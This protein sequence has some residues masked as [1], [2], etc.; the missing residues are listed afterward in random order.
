MNLPGTAGGAWKFALK[1]GQLTARHA[2]R[3]RAVTEEAGRLG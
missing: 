3:L 1:P 2:H